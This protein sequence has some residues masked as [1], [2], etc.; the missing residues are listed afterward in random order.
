LQ[1]VDMY[2]Q[3]VLNIVKFNASLLDS[4]ELQAKLSAFKN[5]YY[6][7]EVDALAPA[8]FIAYQDI[9]SHLL[10]AGL[11]L[12]HSQEAVRWLTHWF[13]PAED[14]ELLTLKNQLLIMTANFKKKPHK[15]ANI[16][17]PINS[18]RLIKEPVLLH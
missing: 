3:V 6:S 1:L 5:W 17:E 9:N 8:E 4:Y 16:H 2:S 10:L 11:D 18:I 13:K 12:K 14:L 7:P 15:R